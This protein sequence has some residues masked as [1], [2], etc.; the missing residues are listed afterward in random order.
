VEDLMAKLNAVVSIR[1]Y[2]DDTISLTL[3]TSFFGTFMGWYN[4]DQKTKADFRNAKKDKQGKYKSVIWLPEVV[5]L[6]V[7]HIFATLAEDLDTSGK[8]KKLADVVLFDEAFKAPKISNIRTEEYV[9][10][11]ENYT[12]KSKNSDEVEKKAKEDMKEHLAKHGDAD[13]MKAFEAKLDD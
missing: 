1:Q 11:Q 4:P 7:N 5:Q 6:Q 12:R 10:K 9:S 3:K 8:T 2:N 13:M